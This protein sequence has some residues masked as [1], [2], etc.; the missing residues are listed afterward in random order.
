[1]QWKWYALAD[2]RGVE[3]EM[4]AEVAGRDERGIVDGDGLHTGQDQVL[5]EL[6]GRGGEA[7]ARGGERG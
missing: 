7:V 3:E 6:S 2:R 1:M 5:A 4:G